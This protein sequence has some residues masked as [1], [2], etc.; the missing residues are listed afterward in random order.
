METY[1]PDLS[2]SSTV[3]TTL[4]QPVDFD[5]PSGGKVRFI[6][7]PGFDLVLP[8][9]SDIEKRTMQARDSL[10]RSRGRIEKM[11]LPELAG[12]C[13]LDDVLCVSGMSPYFILI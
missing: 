7:T 12:T 9:L 1:K 5:T 13:A 10:V 6:D 11:K 3:T 8:S 2:K 4:P